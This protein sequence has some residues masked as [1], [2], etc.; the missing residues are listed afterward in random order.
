MSG[1]L[2]AFLKSEYTNAM[3]EP[4]YLRL[5]DRIYLVPYPYFH[6]FSDYQKAFLN[7]FFD[8]QIKDFELYKKYSLIPKYISLTQKS[9]SH[10]LIVP[11][12]LRHQQLDAPQIAERIFNRAEKVYFKA[13]RLA[14]KLAE[15]YPD[16]RYQTWIGMAHIKKMQKA[17]YEYQVKN[18]RNETA[19][20]TQKIG[21]F[22]SRNARKL[23][24]QLSKIDMPLLR[25][26]ARRWGLKKML[27][28]TVSAA[29]FSACIENESID[30]S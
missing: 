1:Q 21:T 2:L 29:V 30:Q 15:I 13:V 24:N 12:D 14:F 19:Y 25:A 10:R 16:R 4:V 17:Y 23:T 20:L 3:C 5:F 27:A 8:A 28:A 11:F 26:Q 7:D 9:N 18:A 22:L 6:E